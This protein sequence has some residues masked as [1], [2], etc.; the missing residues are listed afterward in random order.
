MRHV[1]QISGFSTLAVL[2]THL[3]AFEKFQSHGK[4]ARNSDLIVWGEAL[5][6]FEASQV[7]FFKTTHG[8]LMLQ[9]HWSPERRS[10]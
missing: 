10:S 7:I 4:D 2:E 8:T 6:V 1:Q 9:V 3:K 5:G